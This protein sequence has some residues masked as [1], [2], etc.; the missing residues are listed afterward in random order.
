[1]IPEPKTD[2]EKY[3][4]LLTADE[5]RRSDEAVEARQSLTE[6][7]RLGAEGEKEPAI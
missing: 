1:L 4:K 2:N 3:L 7:E 6:K 5:R